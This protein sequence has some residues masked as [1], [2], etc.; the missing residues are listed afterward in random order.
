[1]QRPQAILVR[2]MLVAAAM[3]FGASAW[4]NCACFCVE[5]KLATMCTEVDEA[6]AQPNLCPASSSASC[7]QNFSTEAKGSYDAPNESAQ[8]CRDVMVY[9][10]IEGEYVNAKACDVI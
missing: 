8:N 3:V 10:A 2:F 4:G 1:M 6:Q 9:D 7:P 5:G